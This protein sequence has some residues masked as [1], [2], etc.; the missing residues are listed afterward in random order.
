MKNVLKK[1]GR[2]VGYSLLGILAMLILL[3]ITLRIPAVQTFIANKVT[4]FVTDKTGGHIRIEKVR[5]NFIDNVM[6]KGIYV[7]E[8]DGDTL[9]YAGMLEVDISLWRILKQE[10][11]I[12]DIELQD[13][14]AS[15]TQSAETG[16]FNFQ[17]II[18]AFTDSTAVVDTTP[19]NWKISANHAHFENVQFAL[20]I[21]VLKL[22][23]HFGSFDITLDILDL[24]EQAIEADEIELL[25]SYVFLTLATTGDTTLAVDTVIATSDSV[26]KFPL[27][28]IGWAFKLNDLKMERIHI[29]LD[30]AGAV[31]MK[32]FDYNHLD[33]KD[34]N[35][36]LSDLVW[37]AQYFTINIDGIS[38]KSAD[39]TN[40]ENL[41]GYLEATDNMI[42][43]N[44]LKLKTPG[45][46]IDWDAKI[47]Y[48]NFSDL[49]ALDPTMGIEIDLKQ[50]DLKVGDLEPFLPFLWTD[51]I[52][53]P[54]A[55]QAKLNMEIHAEGT[56]GDL[57]LSQVLLSTN[58]VTS[59]DISV[60]VKG[61]PDYEKAVFDIELNEITTTYFDV[62]ALIGD[63][64]IPKGVAKLGTINLTGEI[65]GRMDSINARNVII[66]TSGTTGMAG[67][68]KA[69]GLPNIDKTRF[70][71]DLDYVRT[72]VDEVL[73]LLGGDT[74][75]D[76]VMKLGT[77]AYSGTFNGTITDMKLNG[78]LTTDL[79]SLTA[80][81]SATFNKEYTFATYNAKV[82]L[83]TFDLGTML[84]TPDLGRVSL[85]ATA[86]GEGL[87][88]NTL[89]T[90]M[91]VVI[92][93]LEA[94]KYNYHDIIIG[95]N[96]DKMQFNGNIK[97]DDPNLKFDFDGLV[98]LNDSAPTFGF[99]AHLDTIN[100]HKLHLTNSPLGLS[101]V[102]KV[103][104]TG[105]S[106]TDVDGQAVITDIIVNDSAVFYR[107]DS[108]V[109]EAFD[110]DTGKT[111]QI[112]SPILN[113][114]IAGKYNIEALPRE[115][116]AF[117][118]SYIG[119]VADSLNKPYVPKE[120]QQFDLLLTVSNPQPLLNLVVPGLLLDTASITGRFDNEKNDLII[121]A[122][123]PNIRY[124]SLAIK[125]VNI[126]SGGRGKRFGVLVIVDTL[127]YGSDIDIPHTRLYTF[128]SNDSL[129]YGLNMYN[130]DTT[131]YRLKLGGFMQQKGPDYSFSFD[132]PM[133]LNG[134]TW[135]NLQGNSL[136]IT[137]TGM[138]FDRFGFQNGQRM[139][140][141]NTP[142]TLAGKNPLELQFKN[143]PLDEL[144]ELVSYEGLAVAGTISGKATLYDFTEGLDFISDLSINSIKVNE[145][146]VGD[147]TIIA[148]RKGPDINVNMALTGPNQLTL[149]GK[150]NTQ[151]QNL[152][153][154]LNAGRIDLKVVEPFL[155]DF[156]KESSGFITAEASISGSYKKPEINGSLSFH[157]MSTFIIMAGSQFTLPDNKVSFTSKLIS[158][159]NFKILDADK[160]QATITGSITHDY[161][162]DLRLD[163]RFNTD[164]F[165]FLNTK[166]SLDELF[167][168]KL[169]L[170]IK[171]TVT[172]PISLPKIDL[173]T[174]TKE[175][176]NMTVAPM[177]L[178]EGAQDA[179]YVIYY[180]PNSGDTLERNKRYNVSTLPIDLTIN[181]E[182]TDDAK[183]F[184]L[185][186]PATGDQLEVVAKGDLAVNIPSNGNISII[187]GLEIVSGS[188]QLTQAFLK[189]KFI[190]E[191]GSRIDLSGDPM[192][193]RLNISA[194]YKTRISTYSLIGEQATTLTAQE[195]AAARKP[196]EVHVVL[197]MS[198]PLSSPE[199]S[200]DIRMPDSQGISSIAERR[201][202]QIRQDQNELNKQVFGI[203][204]MN[205]FITDDGVGGGGGVP[206]QNAALKSVSG[207]INQQLS[208]FASKIKGFSVNVDASS[209]QGYSAS[210]A[211]NSVTEVG[212][213]VSQV[214]FDDRLEIRAGADVNLESNTGNANQGSGL[215][216]W[217]GDFVLEYKLS[218]SG[219]Y[220]V[221]VF[222]TTAYSL[223]YQ[224]NVNRTGVGLTFQHSF[225]KMKKKLNTPKKPADDVPTPPVPK[226][227]PPIE[228]PKTEEQE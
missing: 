9:L 180:S 116:M 150:I 40:I 203:L 136:I 134:D 56:L 60:T 112:R 110:S 206:G 126:R 187:G 103:D 76:M 28:D 184:V 102:M 199:L 183:F 88:I 70:A 195:Q 95:G 93:E 152:S 2:I 74:L 42:T 5:I 185:V 109:V 171:A 198:G 191:K 1:L 37:E 69:V 64:G 204:L 62:L 148:L 114:Y 97:I 145:N 20:D 50:T 225:R 15:I 146:P 228:S 105:L 156:I 111:I 101:M 223:L 23:S 78:L 205:S 57:Q 113:G 24:N 190:I 117:I 96:V 6:L 71:I 90:E 82:G 142:D 13:A 68:I 29:K 32:G 99:N 127:T 65:K 121:A 59:L 119:N 26:M 132:R 165:T 44:D 162:T 175:G 193:A 55:R 91:D 159:G 54:Q 84:A 77:I 72:H 202:Q 41:S 182:I 21:E 17:Y 104:L 226:N 209:Y 133:I 108:F 118:D 177:T 212:V 164:E 144:S 22:N 207:L 115:L 19:S 189:R 125:N 130:A 172:G 155:K 208:R 51:S 66:K 167:Y 216:Q 34:I 143:F 7:E 36:E 107:M 153:G 80:D 46:T 135:E 215:T 214:V 129:R 181:L 200:F 89:H 3:L 224:N 52:L 98:N 75:P 67:N 178:Q 222:N 197:M 18:D 43:I 35:I 25:D 87:T 81:L 151:T 131:E 140:Q 137:P 38:F 139:F 173:T 79:G 210:D 217:A 16:D 123:I 161:F 157:D 10:I 163:L 11:Y 141:I 179:S 188:Y 138:T 4:A 53:A 33:L 221:K 220:R 147:I 83:D 12:D 85:D 39:G 168:G 196:S 128:V 219:K 31:S 218:E 100:L 61:L 154:K 8:P 106:S 94:M 169:V 73:P 201:L 27:P 122:S 174:V 120:P 192:D 194:L 49:M 30:Q 213:T 14:T 86:K 160:K 211:N 58:S 48:K 186:D 158:L 92:T 227:P 124:D 47:N 63:I 166:P 45:I 170:G 149:N 176:T